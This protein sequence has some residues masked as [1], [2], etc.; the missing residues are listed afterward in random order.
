MHSVDVYDSVTLVDFL[1]DG[2]RWHLTST[3]DFT[4]G[5]N[6]VW[7]TG[8]LSDS[9]IKTST[10]F[11]SIETDDVAAMQLND[12]DLVIAYAD[13]ATNNFRAMRIVSDQDRDMI[14]DTHDA[15]PTIGNQW[16]DSIQTIMVIIQMGL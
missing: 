5:N 16:E 13:S 11:F 12:D 3:N 6:L 1:V 4:G 15:L 9:S 14:P 2:D 7:T 10:K 8:L